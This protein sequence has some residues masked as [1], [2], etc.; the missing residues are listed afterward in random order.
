[1]GLILSEP[2]KKVVEIL[3]ILTKMSVEDE[4]ITQNALTDFFPRRPLAAG[5]R[6]PGVAS[7]A[8]GL[9]YR[10]PLSCKFKLFKFRVF[11]IGSQLIH[12]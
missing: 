1:M 11:L 9:R 7:A 12:A 10:Y 5:R 4:K 2:I 3:K 6:P 8:C